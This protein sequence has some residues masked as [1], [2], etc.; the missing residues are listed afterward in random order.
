MSG[1]FAGTFRR[2]NCRDK[3]IWSDVSFLF[4][5]PFER[6]PTCAPFQRLHRSIPRS[7]LCERVVQS[8]TLPLTLEATCLS[9]VSE[10][11][12]YQY[13]PRTRVDGIE[14]WG[15]QHV[16]A[17]ARSKRLR[18]PIGAS[19]AHLAWASTTSGFGALRSVPGKSRT[20]CVGRT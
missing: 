19:R 14:C 4:C 5:N 8:S 2:E 1:Q 17:T 7:A 15:K 10:E 20:S 16:R 3:H 12:P 11:D 9:A 6:V 13:R 18:N